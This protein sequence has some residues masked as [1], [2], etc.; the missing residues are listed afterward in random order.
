[1]WGTS[2]E[3]APLFD[4]PEAQPVIFEDVLLELLFGPEPVETVFPEGV[5]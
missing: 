3:Q 1:M 2:G 5:V 4:D